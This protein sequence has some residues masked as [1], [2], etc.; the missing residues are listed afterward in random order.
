MCD[1]WIYNFTW[2]HLSLWR[3]LVLCEQKKMDYSSSPRPSLPP[4]FSLTI[5]KQQYKK[6][7]TEGKQMHVGMETS[8]G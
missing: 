6:K 7:V 3:F 8:G 1:V 5:P 4:F 2:K